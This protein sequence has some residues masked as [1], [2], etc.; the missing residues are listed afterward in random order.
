MAIRNTLLTKSIS[1]LRTIYYLDKDWKSYLKDKEYT[2]SDV[3]VFRQEKK[4]FRFADIEYSCMDDHNERDPRLPIQKKEEEIAEF[5]KKHGIRFDVETKID[6]SEPFTDGSRTERNVRILKDGRFVLPKELSVKLLHEI[7]STNYENFDN[8]LRG[9]C[10][11]ATEEKMPE[12]FKKAAA[13]AVSMICDDVA[14]CRRSRPESG[15]YIIEI[16]VN[17]DDFRYTEPGGDM[18]GIIFKNE[19]V[20]ALKGTGEK[21]LFGALVLEGVCRELTEKDSFGVLDIYADGSDGHSYDG[22]E[23]FM[24]VMFK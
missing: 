8:R 7:C 6:Y 24:I 22:C 5:C 2:Y 1:E 17:A 21:E 10:W 12:A 20:A 11:G 14:V 4:L 16:V 9:A 3:S 23:M 15:D 18:A 13:A 19:G